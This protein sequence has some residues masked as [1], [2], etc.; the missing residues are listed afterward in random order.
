MDVTK[1]D[2]LRILDTMVADGAPQSAV[3]ARAVMS[4]FFKWCVGRDEIPHSPVD[5]VERPAKPNARNRVLNDQEIR[6]LWR[7]CGRAARRGPLPKPGRRIKALGVEVGIA[8]CS[9]Q[10]QVAALDLF[11]AS[12]LEDHR[13]YFAHRH[14][15]SAVSA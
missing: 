7:A 10:E 14:A 5:G 13:G 9:I 12:R 11:V 4:K 1:R 15:R 8:R 6:W 2:I 3:L